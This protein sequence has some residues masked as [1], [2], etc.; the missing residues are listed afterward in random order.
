MVIFK[1]RAYMIKSRSRILWLFPILLAIVYGCAT[2]LPPTYAP[3]GSG[4]ILEGPV[5]TLAGEGDL[6]VAV[7]K[8]G[9]FIKKDD[10]PWTNQEV[11][12]M[13]KFSRVTC[14][15][16]DKGVVY[17]GSDGEGLH[18]LSEGTWEVKTSRYGGLPDDGVL[19]IAVDG[20]D[21][22]LSGTTLWVGTR[23]G[24]A[25]FREGK[26][27]VFDPDGD[28]LVAM[29]GKSGAGAGKVYVGPGFKLGQKGGDSARFR[30]PVSA[31]G[32]GPDRVVFGNRDSRLAIVSQNAVATIS[33]REDLK[34]NHLRVDKDTIWAGTDSGLLWGGLKGR[35]EGK[36]WPIHR[37][38]MGWSGT[39]FGSRDT[40]DFEY[41]WKSV[42]YN[43][44]MIV[45]LEKTGTDI[46]VAHRAERGTSP[47]VGRFKD[48]FFQESGTDQSAS[49][50]ITDIRRY[51][52]I[53][54]YI[55]RKQ[56]MRYE[57][58]GQGPDIG[59]EPSALYIDPDSMK[60]YVGTTKGLW[61]LEQ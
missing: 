24:V 60:V 47:A 23:K 3:T 59:G 51:V 61:E 17:V 30:P 11:P 7:N 45:G 18:I 56:M 20:S 34:F 2:P 9:L 27:S 31:I 54:E 38:Y 32:V 40:R 25:A 21:E 39:L 44:A 16:V 58:Y 1:W 37:I 55:A 28:W 49:E 13:S 50:P 41:R 57:S 43:T 46:W 29:T 6:V 8:D 35:A 5:L 26:W 4:R 33:L 53:K 36:P 15:A 22:G 14:L 52:N 42:G 48:T 10:G 12:G 19:S